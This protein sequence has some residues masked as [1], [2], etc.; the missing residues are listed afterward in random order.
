MLPSKSLCGDKDPVHAKEQIWVLRS[1]NPDWSCLTASR[2]LE[3]AETKAT[4]FP[5]TRWSQKYWQCVSFARVLV[6][7]TNLKTGL[8]LSTPHFMAM[9]LGHRIDHRSPK[10]PSHAPGVTSL[11]HQSASRSALHYTETAALSPDY[12]ATGSILKTSILF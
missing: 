9:D 5:T 10:K 6:T 12:M 1:H 4:F 7:T 8:L 3:E 2:V 11:L